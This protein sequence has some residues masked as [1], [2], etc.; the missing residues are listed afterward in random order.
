MGG[1]LA[2]STSRLHFP[3]V[4]AALINFR[5]NQQHFSI[6]SETCG[7]QAL[8]EPMEEAY[9][10]DV[11]CGNL[12]RR[13][14][15]ALKDPLQRSGEG[16]RDIGLAQVFVPAGNQSARRHLVW[17]DL[18]P[19]YISQRPPEEQGRSFTLLPDPRPPGKENY[20]VSGLSLGGSTR[21]RRC[22]RGLG[23]SSL[24]GRSE[25]VWSL[26]RVWVPR[27][28]GRDKRNRIPC[29]RLW[30]YVTVRRSV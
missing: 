27:T 23:R 29:V 7:S 14:H 18:L 28:R 24:K 13:L 8:A 11:S 19:D 25:R 6:S 9:L 30:P 26:G 5:G 20:K 10:Q 17:V 4:L 21:L 2:R 1:S 3:Q 15:L 22:V 16:S 12:T